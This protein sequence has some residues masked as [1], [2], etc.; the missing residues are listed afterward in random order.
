MSYNERSVL[1]V[2]RKERIESATLVLLNGFSADWRPANR[3]GRTWAQ[4]TS[5][6]FARCSY[7]LRV[8]VCVT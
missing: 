2:E 3:G 5:S 4:I 6:S 1:R 8:T 7:R